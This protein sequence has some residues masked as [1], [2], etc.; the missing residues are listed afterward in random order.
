MPL[1]LEPRTR[2][3]HLAAVEPDLAFRLAPAMRRPVL[4]TP[5]AGTARR[6]RI[7][8]H[9]LPS[10]SSLAAPNFRVGLAVDVICLF[11]ASLSSRGISTPA[12]GKQRRF[13]YFNNDRDIPRRFRY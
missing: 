6:S 3:L 12:R 10:A 13:F 5:M 7:G 9:H 8:L 1:G 11:M 2:D 4:A